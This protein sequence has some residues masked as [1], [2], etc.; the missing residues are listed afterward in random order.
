MSDNVLE[1]VDWNIPAQEIRPKN[2]KYDSL[3][4]ILEVFFS[5]AENYGMKDTYF[6]F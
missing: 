5:G 1:Q 3:A 4:I 2:I 6:P